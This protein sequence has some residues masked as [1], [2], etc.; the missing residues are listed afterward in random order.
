MD[1]ENQDEEII[2]LKKPVLLHFAPTWKR[3]LA[4]IIDNLLFTILVSV[5]LFWKMSEVMP[6]MADINPQDLPANIAKMNET[7]KPILEKF[8]I[9]NMILFYI[10]FISYF[11][12]LTKARGQTVGAMVLKIA[13]I[14]IENKPLN[15]G[16][17]AIRGMFLAFGMQFWFIPFIF[18]F[19]PVYH[20]RIHDYLSNTVVIDLPLVDDSD[21]SE[22]DKKDI[23]EDEKLS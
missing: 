2:K 8:F 14:P 13:V 20:Q 16:F 21:E 19:N 10:I 18:V 11:T 23:V 6:P 4:Y 12:L 1:E 5:M 3:V 7:M 15:I 17:Y 9:D 22:D